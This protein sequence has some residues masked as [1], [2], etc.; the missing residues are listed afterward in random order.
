MT[1]KLQEELQ[2]AWFLKKPPEKALAD[3]EKTLNEILARN[4]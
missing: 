1:N 3:A 4:K 2:N